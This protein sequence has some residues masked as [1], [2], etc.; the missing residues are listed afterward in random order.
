[1]RAR[2]EFDAQHEFETSTTLTFISTGKSQTEAAVSAA[3]S[4]AGRRR[5]GQ[6]RPDDANR[7]VLGR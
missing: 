6:T 1:M 3:R 5:R 4:I 2:R 7:C